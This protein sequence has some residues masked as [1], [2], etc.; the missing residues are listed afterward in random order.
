ME[1][2]YD[3]P[4]FFEQYLQLRADERNY[5]DLIEQP[6]M[7]DLIGS[8][9]GLSFLDI[10]CGYGNT[11]RWIA[12]H[13]A[14]RVLGIDCS[15]NMVQKAMQDNQHPNIEYLVRDA[16]HLESVEGKFD[17]VV[18]SLTF[19][20]LEDFP[21][22]VRDIKDLLKSDGRLVFSM[23]HPIYTARMTQDPDWEFDSE[24]H[25]T[26]YHLDHYGLEGVR[27]VRW[28]DTDITKYHRRTDTIIQALVDEGFSLRR[29]I[30]P[31]PSD[32][33]MA[34]YERTVQELHRPAYLIIEAISG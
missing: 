12:K 8:C 31:V 23:E 29:I 22:T 15:E 27:H 26:A 14:S 30:E 25:K 33:L 28:L 13:G 6:I 32:E 20:Y 7:Y 10:G 24:G 2:I 1:A 34:T 16:N 19:H 9:E 21:K 3:N 4:F 11:C 5:N 17:V 18:S